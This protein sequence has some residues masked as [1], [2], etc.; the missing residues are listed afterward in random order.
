MNEEKEKEQQK[1]DLSQVPGRRDHHLKRSGSD[2]NVGQDK[3]RH[4]V[5]QG[6]E[7]TREL[8]LAVHITDRRRG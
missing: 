1:G 2:E 7:T 6:H 3:V 8:E 5:T 4:H